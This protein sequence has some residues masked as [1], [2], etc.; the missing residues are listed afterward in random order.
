MMMSLYC[1]LFGI[2]ENLLL[3]PLRDGLLDVRL[4]K[5]YESGGGWNGGRREAR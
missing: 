2:A 4:R 3:E 5:L 1:K